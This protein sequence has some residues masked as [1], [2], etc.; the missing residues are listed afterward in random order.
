MLTVSLLVLL[1]A[2]TLLLPVFYLQFALGYWFRPAER[3]ALEEAWALRFDDVLLASH[4]HQS[5]ATFRE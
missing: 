2:L 1:G 3:V 5:D 4:V